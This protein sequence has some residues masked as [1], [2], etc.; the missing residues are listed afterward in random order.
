MPCRATPR[1][2]DACRVYFYSVSE[3]AGGKR[4]RAPP[5]IIIA[6]TGATGQVTLCGNRESDNVTSSWLVVR[7]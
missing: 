5:D 6:M 1:D 7:R 3:I 2:Q 4:A